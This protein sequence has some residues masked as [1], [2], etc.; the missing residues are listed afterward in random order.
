MASLSHLKPHLDILREKYEEE[1]DEGRNR[2][3]PSSLLNELLEQLNTITPHRRSIS[4]PSIV[5][6]GGRWNEQQDAQEFFQKLTG[7]VE[8]EALRRMK[9]LREPKGLEVLAE[10]VE[11]EKERKV[12]GEVLE[13]EGEEVVD[14]SDKKEGKLQDTIPAELEN[15]FEGLLAQRVGCL[16]CG[17]VEAI[18]MQTFT[19]LSL[20]MP[21]NV[22][23]HLFTP[24]PK[25]T[26]SSKHAH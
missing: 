23:S 5:R 15:P 9:E 10:I 3:S 18:R 17:Y 4:A 8:K 22:R 24:P 2:Y 11:K 13:G 12:E 25:L 26:I 16:Q 6:V 19:S 7:V 20:P 14:K 21:S 1:E